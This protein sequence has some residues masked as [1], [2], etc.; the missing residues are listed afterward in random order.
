[1]ERFFMAVHS[2]LLPRST[3][4]FTTLCRDGGL[5][6]FLGAMFIDTENAKPMKK[7]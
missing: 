4:N 5:N 2:V 3:G 1:M 7:S 6:L